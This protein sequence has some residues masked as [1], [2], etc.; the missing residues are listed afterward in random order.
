[1]I[2]NLVFYGVGLKSSE[3][4]VNPYLSFSLSAFVE[5]MAYVLTHVILDRLGR[6]LPYV[7]FLFSAGLSCFLIGFYGKYIYLFK[8]KFLS[9]VVQLYNCRLDGVF[10]MFFITNFIYNFMTKLGILTRFNL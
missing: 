9:T 3:L 1:M 6:K 10:F 8:H 5:F 4:G 7:F 2:N